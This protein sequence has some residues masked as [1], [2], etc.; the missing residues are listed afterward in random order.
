[1]PKHPAAALRC[2][3]FPRGSLP[4]ALD[5]LFR[6]SLSALLLATFASAPASATGVASPA[7]PAATGK[8]E[9][10]SSL[11]LKE[12]VQRRGQIASVVVLFRYKRIKTGYVT[13]KEKPQVFYYNASRSTLEFDC[14]R[15][16]SRIVHTVFFS[17]R[18]GLGNVVH[19][20]AARSDWT[21]EFDRR[22]LGSPF[23]LACGS[24]EA[25]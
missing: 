11:A 13:N 24:G 12:T 3:R 1:M 17:D 4:A 2:I 8:S 22:S 5:A 6:A 18:A 23:K 16:K 20:Q 10:A 9:I 7:R 19:Q 25:G 15:K 21:D 14:D